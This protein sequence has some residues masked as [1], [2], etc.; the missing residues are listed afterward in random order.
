MATAIPERFSDVVLQRL[1][2]LGS[3][4]QRMV[5]AAAVFGPRFDWRLLG[6]VTALAEPGIGAAIREAI[7][8]QLLVTDDQT[9]RPVFRHALTAEVIAADLDPSDRAA[10]QLRAADAVASSGSGDP[11]ELLALEAR[12]RA[13]A[14]DSENAAALLTA[15]AERAAAAG[16][17]A[18]AEQHLRAAAELGTGNQRASAALLEVLVHRGRTEPALLLGREL[19]ELGP[20]GRRATGRR[21]AADGQSLPDRGAAGRGAAAPDRRTAH[22]QRAAAS[23][24]RIGPGPRHPRGHR[25]GAHRRSRA[26][27]APGGGRSRGRG[28][29][30]ADVRVARGGRPVRPAARS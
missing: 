29:A 10:L 18:A 25:P 8:A 11:G 15:V 30:R 3:M 16:A 6:P 17:L 19:L 14:G 2:A 21:R 24:D 1:D 28:R 20:P 9:G 13:A 12:L 5:R 22:H 23:R 7:D 4:A 27:R 26:S